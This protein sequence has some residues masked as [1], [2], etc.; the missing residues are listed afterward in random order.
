MEEENDDLEYHLNDI[1]DMKKIERQIKSYQLKSK[2]MTGII[3]ALI[4]LFMGV[5]GFFIYYFVINKGN[6]KNNNTNTN[7]NTNDNTNN[8]KVFNFSSLFNISYGDDVNKIENTFKVN[9][10]NYNQLFGNINQGKDYVHN[11]GKNTYDLFIPEDL[12][13]NKYNKILLFIHGGFW[14]M[15]NKTLFTPSCLDFAKKGYITVSMD[16]SLLNNTN[17]NSSIFRILDEVATAI[18][19]IKKALKEKGFKEE[20][21]ELAIGGASSGAHI[22]LLYA[23]LYKKSPLPIK[24]A[25]N[26]VGPITDNFTYYYQ[27]KDP[28]KPLDNIEQKDIE[29]AINQTTIVPIKG[30]LNNSN[31]MELVNLF[32]GYKYN[33]IKMNLTDPKCGQAYFQ[34]Q[35]LFPIKYA[36]KNVVPTLC[37]YT[38]KDMV[39]GVRQYSYFQSIFAKKDKIALQ[40]CK[41]LPHEMYVKDSPD[42]LDCFSGLSI[43]ILDF[44]K[45]YFS[46]NK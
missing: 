3:I 23:Y 17:Y 12:D 20:K 28:N 13:K 14:T 18:K 26:L 7:A 29:R 46:K 41:N 37:L 21:L 11:P 39:V 30:A 40:Y 24:F 9:A 19:S 43:K 35:F 8:N 4:L 1:G 31:P 44:S 27:I 36:D 15:G 42:T 6:D 25:I 38:G 32:L 16:Y 34:F 22:A 2:V 45:Q 33:E 10:S 5:F